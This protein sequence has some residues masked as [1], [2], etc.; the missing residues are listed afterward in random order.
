MTDLLTFTLSSENENTFTVFCI[1]KA[2]KIIK[3]YSTT[4]NGSTCTENTIPE[5][6]Y[7]L[8]TLYIN[9]NGNIMTY[10]DTLTK[11]AVAIKKGDSTN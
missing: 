1:D 3:C 8:G 10:T 5:Y 4:D 11:K 6:K 7:I 2:T 9:H